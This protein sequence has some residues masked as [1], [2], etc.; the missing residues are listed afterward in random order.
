MDLSVVFVLRTHADRSVRTPFGKRGQ[1]DDGPLV[2]AVG[3]GFEEAAGEVVLVPAGLDEDDRTFGFEACVEVV[4]VPVP[5]LV[6]KAFAVRLL[7]AFDGVV[8][9]DQI[10]TKAGHARSD[11]HGS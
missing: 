10:G 5:D 9:D 7:T 1:I 6:A 8:D 3:L 11:A 2:A 4:V